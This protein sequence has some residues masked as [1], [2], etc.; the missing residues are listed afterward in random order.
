[1]PPPLARSQQVVDIWDMPEILSH[2]FLQLKSYAFSVAPVCRQWREIVSKDSFYRSYSKLHWNTVLNGDLKNEDEVKKYIFE[3]LNLENI[4]LRMIQLT[5]AYHQSRDSL[6]LVDIKSLTDLEEFS[7]ETKKNVILK[8]LSEIINAEDK[9]I[10]KQVIDNQYYQVYD[11]YSFKDVRESLLGEGWNGSYR[12][13]DNQGSFLTVYFDCYCQP[14][15]NR[16]HLRISFQKH[17]YTEKHIIIWADAQENQASFN[18]EKIL[19]FRSYLGFGHLSLLNLF[20][21][22]VTT[23]GKL[24]SH[25]QNRFES[26]SS[27]DFSHFWS[28]MERGDSFDSMIEDSG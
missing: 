21:F 8:W 25:Y 19:L 22:I 15:H 27:D 23:M 18:Y 16:E 9:K 17:K 14:G 4:P 28:K 6:Y 26:L 20:C 5:E 12:I 24:F 13:Y 10:L 2:I 11:K 1:L 3:R 7:N